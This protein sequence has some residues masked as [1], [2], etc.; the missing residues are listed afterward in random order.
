VAAFWTCSPRGSAAEGCPGVHSGLV[1]VQSVFPSER[2]DKIMSNSSCVASL[3]PT[4][5]GLKVFHNAFSQ[6]M[7][8]VNYTVVSGCLSSTC[9]MIVKAAN[10]PSSSAL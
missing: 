7:M 5:P 4:G 3:T 8:R 6:S 1:V 9:W 10:K 2:M